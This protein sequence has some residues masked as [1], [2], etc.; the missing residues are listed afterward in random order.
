MTS[1]LLLFGAGGALGSA[2][3]DHLLG[4]DFTLHTVEGSI[5]K[6]ATAHRPLSYDDDLE[7]SSFSGLPSL[8]AVVWAQ[9]LNCGDTVTSFEPADLQRLL[10]GNVLFNA[11]SLQALLAADRLRE[12]SRLVVVSSTGSSKVGPTS[13]LTPSPKQRCKG[14][15]SP[16]ISISAPA[17]S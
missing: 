11:S 12:G 9:G 7:P 2:I 16:V 1:D 4:H 10:Q 5:L 17:A 6:G 13:S 8:E 3:G 15:C 14:W